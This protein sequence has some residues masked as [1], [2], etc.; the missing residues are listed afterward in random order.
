MFVETNNSLD[1]N[2]EDKDSPFRNRLFIIDQS[3]PVDSVALSP[4][5]TYTPT[6]SPERRRTRPWTNTSQG[7]APDLPA[8][9]HWFVNAF[10]A[11]SA[12]RHRSGGSLD[13]AELK[14]DVTELKTKIGG[15]E[16]GISSILQM[17]REGL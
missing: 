13:V 5:D 15:L 11:H 1:G 12:T 7:S 4:T 16:E 8:D 17:L 3:T 10:E 6:P 2:N 9:F 14:A